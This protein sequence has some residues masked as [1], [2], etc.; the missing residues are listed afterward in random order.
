M[1]RNDETADLAF[2]IYYDMNGVYLRESP[3]TYV[4]VLVVHVETLKPILV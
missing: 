3:K 1:E 4:A 2:H